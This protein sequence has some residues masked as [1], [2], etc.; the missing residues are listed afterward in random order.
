M[1]SITCDYDECSCG[2]K[3]YSTDEWLVHNVIKHGD[4]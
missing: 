1:N 2:K 3:I 4:D